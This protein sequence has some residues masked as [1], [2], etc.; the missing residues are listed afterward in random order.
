MK[1]YFDY[2]KYYTDCTGK[3]VPSDFDIHHID[4]DRNNNHI[5]NLVAIPRVLHQD[6]HSAFIDVMPYL[7][8]GLK[9]DMPTSSNLAGYAYFS[10]SLVLFNRY[11]DAKVKVTK[12]IDYKIHLL[13]LMPN[14]H[15]YSYEAHYINK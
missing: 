5:D 6:Y 9:P 1:N 7:D 4:L 14:I 10:H 13:G 3:N 15:N 12:W 2:R 11:C 8:D